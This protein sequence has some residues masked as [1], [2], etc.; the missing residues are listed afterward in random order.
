MKA[1]IV[2]K[3]LALSGEDREKVLRDADVVHVYELRDGICFLDPEQ[4]YDTE[5]L[6][7]YLGFNYEW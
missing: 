5:A 6:A 1:A 2:I 7:E 3:E 4:E